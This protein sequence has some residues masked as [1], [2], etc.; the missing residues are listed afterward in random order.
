MVG[1]V[2]GGLELGEEGYR[3]KEELGVRFHE[4]DSVISNFCLRT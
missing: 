1:E 4:T 2:K 3:I